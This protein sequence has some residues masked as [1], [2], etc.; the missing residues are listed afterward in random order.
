MNEKKKNIIVTSIDLFADKGFYSTSIQEI[1]DKSGVS[2]GAFYLHFHSKDELMLEIFKYYY[3]LMQE[4]IENVIDEAL[5]PK[6]NFTKQVEVQFHEILKHKSFIL[7]QLKEQAFTL[8]KE[9]YDFIRLKELETQKWYKKNLVSIYG[10]E[11]E[12]YIIDLQILFEGMKNNYFQVLIHGEVD[13][14]I[15]KLASFIVD[16][17][18]DIVA[19]L[20]TTKKE[21]MLTQEMVFSLFS[22]LTAPEEL[23]K[24]EVMNNLLEMQKVLNDADF[25]EKTINELQG[26]ID[27][28]ISEVKKQDS[29]TFVIQGMLANFKGMHQFDQY[30]KVISEKLGI[31][32]L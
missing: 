4:N 21:P 16:R 23:V 19:G 17:L 31:R 11:I 12:P 20:L 22:D 14:Q 1:A 26:V 7:T 32:I 6:V 28:L 13:I 2:K 25:Y 9:L 18:D 10:G 24:K 27:F 3:N 5:S 30:R 15:S 29:K 8:N